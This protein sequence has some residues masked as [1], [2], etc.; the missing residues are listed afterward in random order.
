M[1]ATVT[2]IKIKLPLS[3]QIISKTMLMKRHSVIAPLLMKI[4]GW[5]NDEVRKKEIQPYKLK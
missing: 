5:L 2:T 4:F 1:A 3:K